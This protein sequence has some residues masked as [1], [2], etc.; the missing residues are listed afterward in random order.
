MP[1]LLTRCERE[2]LA[3]IEAD[4][5]RDCPALDHALRHGAFRG[6]PDQRRR[7][8]SL[9]AWPVAALA[10][11]GAAL[12]VLGLALPNTLALVTGFYLTPLS[13]LGLWIP[14]RRAHPA[15]PCPC[16]R[17]PALIHHHRRHP[18]RAQ[19]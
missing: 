4:L 18:G 7:S 17:N 8:Y 1:A 10:S 14:V 13:F 9:Q 5:R 3:E 11:L 16:V 12:V 15:R 19:P 6:L 2:R